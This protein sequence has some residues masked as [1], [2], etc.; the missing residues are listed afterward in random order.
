MKP[1]VYKLHQG[2]YLAVLEMRQITRGSIEDLAIALVQ[3]GITADQL[4]L[5]DWRE[6]AELLNS[7]EQKE[8][9]RAM[10]VM[11][12]IPGPAAGLNVSA[13]GGSAG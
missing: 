6:G 2:V 10:A 4:L 9:R 11:Q 12:G 13:I 1:S 5:G 8:L 3:Q 7:S